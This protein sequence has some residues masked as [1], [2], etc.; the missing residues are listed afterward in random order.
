MV[1]EKQSQIT[2]FFIGPHY[3]AIMHKPP[4]AS[5]TSHNQHKRSLRRLLEHKDMHIMLLALLIRKPSYGYDLIKQ[6]EYAS[7]GLYVPSAGVI[8]PTLTLL[9]EQGY[10][11]AKQTQG[12]RKIFSVTSAGKGYLVANHTTEIAIFAKLKHA[13][14]LQQGSNLSEEVEQ[15]V[16]NFRALL[17]HKMATKQL[18]AEQAKRIAQIINDAVQQIEQVNNWLIEHDTE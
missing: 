3:T 5:T 4:L 17:R 7:S 11:S 2:A 8:Y 6:I 1:I 18:S 10:I 12:K 9:E 15:A 13:H 14:D 16:A